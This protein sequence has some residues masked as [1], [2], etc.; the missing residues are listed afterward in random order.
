MTKGLLEILK[1]DLKL[2][3]TQTLIHRTGGGSISKVFD[4]VPRDFLRYAKKDFSEKNE[5][6]LINSLTNAKR[7]IDCQIDTALSLYGISFETLPEA[8][9]DIIK[10]HPDID[11]SLPFKLKLI[12]ALDFAPSSLISKVRGFRNELEHFYKKPNNKEVKDSI[13]L[14]E[15]FILAVESKTKV[16]E[17]GFLLTDKSNFLG[18]EEDIGYYLKYRN[19]LNVT[20]ENKIIQLESKVNGI[21][22]NVQILDENSPDYYFF[23]LL[24]NN[25]EDITDF[26]TAFA[27]FLKFINHPIPEKHI[28]VSFDL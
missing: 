14:A 26:K 24:M 10:C 21:E 13:E 25:M 15:L 18:T 11:S 22:K 19:Y 9:N 23:V 1:N 16:I 20:Y 3:F 5:K 7:A 4:I 2:D 28:S 27:L 6:G 8:S 17:D 12:S